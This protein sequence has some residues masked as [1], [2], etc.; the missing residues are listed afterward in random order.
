MKEYRYNL[1]D[2]EFFNSYGEK[3][4]QCVP[5]L[6][7]QEHAVW[8]IFL[9]T[10][11]DQP[12]DF[13]EVA[14]WSAAV[15]CDFKADTPPM[16]R[17][18]TEDISADPTAGSVTVRLD[19]GT[20]EFL[21][22]IDG[23]PGK[24]ANF[25]LCGLNSAG[26]RVL[27][28]CFPITARMTIDPDPE[29][30]V[31]TPE[32]LAT[33]TYARLAI[34]GALASGGYVTSGGAAAIAGS[35]VSGA[36]FSGSAFDTLIGSVRITATSG[37]VLVSA[38]GM[39]TSIGSGAIIGSGA[40]GEQ[41]VMSDGVVYLAASDDDGNNQARITAAPGSATVNVSDATNEM[42][43]DIE[44]T[45]LFVSGRPVLTELATRIDSETTSAAIEV[46]SGGTSYIFTQPLTCLSITS[47]V[48]AEIEDQFQF[49][50]AS[51]GQVTVPASCGF[52]PPDFVFEGGK[53]YLMAILGGNV[54]AGEYTA[55]SSI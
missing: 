33:K 48:R 49:T 9:R 26:E 2:A 51:G 52:A 40:S 1:D 44:P 10:R 34:S 29:V 7:Y 41:L 23:S 35:A 27:Y 12:R 37:G 38:G 46:L 5:E 31:H 21:A 14:A 17:A 43:I 54:I 53:S 16:C 13:T 20:S 19:A 42:S 25:E 22:A 36:I 15:D 18:L 24:S 50:L 4:S 8:R 28:L 45:G 47:V 39:V 32:T 55:G 6:C 30:D 3:L 11:D